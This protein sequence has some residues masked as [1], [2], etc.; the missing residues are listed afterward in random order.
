MAYR[1]AVNRT[2]IQIYIYIYI[3]AQIQKSIPMLLKRPTVFHGIIVMFFIESATYSQLCGSSYK[4]Q[5]DSPLKSV[6]KSEQLTD[7]ACLQ[8]QS[9]GIHLNFC[10]GIVVYRS[11]CLACMHADC[12]LM[13]YNQSLDG[14]QQII[15][16]KEPLML[17]TSG[18]LILVALVK[19]TILW[20]GDVGMPCAYTQHT[21][22]ILK[23]C[24]LIALK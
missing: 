9:E 17:C 16:Y 20:Y 3:Y 24:D 18:S 15:S 21:K 11:P 14:C 5:L 19:H 4:T 23:I 13:S 22:E 8:V 7:S 12:Q 1:K 2:I 10:W 6:Q